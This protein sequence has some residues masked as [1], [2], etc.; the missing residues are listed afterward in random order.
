MVN[1]SNIRDREVINI[2]DGR[3]LGIVSDVEID[4]EEGKIISI[5]IPRPGRFLD[6]FG[7]D[8]DMVIPWNCIK[9]IG[10]DVILVDSEEREEIQEADEE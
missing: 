8:S 10:V 9:K 1:A 3:K 5:I 4:F 7:R 2:N 6:F